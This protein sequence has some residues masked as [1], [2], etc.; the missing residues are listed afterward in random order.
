MIYGF[1]KKHVN[2]RMSFVLLNVSQHCLVSVEIQCCHERKMQK[3]IISLELD[4]LWIYSTSCSPLESWENKE[5]LIS[6]SWK[7]IWNLTRQL[8]LFSCLSLWVHLRRVFLNSW[9]A[10]VYS[11]CRNFQTDDGFK[12]GLTSCL[13]R[14]AAIYHWL[15]GTSQPGWWPV[16]RRSL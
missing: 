6:N 11:G 16:R 12:S 3:Q 10:D 1:K 7:V 4:W 15:S 9:L 13:W 5:F 14:Q 2:L 8:F